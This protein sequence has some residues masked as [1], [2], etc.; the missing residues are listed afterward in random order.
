[1]QSCGTGQKRPV[2]TSSWEGLVNRLVDVHEIPQASGRLVS[3]LIRMD[4]FDPVDRFDAAFDFYTGVMDIFTPPEKR[5][6]LTGRVEHWELG[7]LLLMNGVSDEL[8]IRRNRAHVAQDD[9]D[10]WI[11]RATRSGRLISCTDDRSYAANRGEIVLETLAEPFVDTWSPAGWVSVMIPRDALPELVP[12]FA[13]HGTGPILGTAASLLA[14]FL[15]ALADRLPYAEERDRDRFARTLRMMIAS[16]LQVEVKAGAKVREA[17]TPFARERVRRVIRQNLS[18]ALL[19]PDR[20]SRM[21]G[22]SRST[23]YRMFEPYGGVVHYLQSM[24]LDRVYRDLTEVSQNTKLTIAEIAERRGFHNTPAF[25]RAF[26]RQFG[27]TPGEVRANAE[28]GTRLPVQ[29]PRR[30][31]NGGIDF[32]ML[33]K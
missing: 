14:D 18:S 19:D 24:R 25:N 32:S 3:H 13:E 9:L 28:A 31:T 29:T 17:N 30:D 4:D 2:A 22:I 21:S 8:T 33:L 27:C 12:Y 15:L 11:I 26:K 5:R 23:L 1:V 16:C 7:E 10:H 6:L 20:I